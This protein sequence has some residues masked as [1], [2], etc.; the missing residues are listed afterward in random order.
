[1]AS[2]QRVCSFDE[3]E[4]LIELQCPLPPDMYKYKDAN[5]G[6]EKSVYT[7]ARLFHGKFWI[8][9]PETGII[10]EAIVKAK[11]IKKHQMRLDQMR[12]VDD[13]LNA[14]KLTSS[15]QLYKRFKKSFVSCSF[16]L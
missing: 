12:A 10:Y 8:R 5:D 13:Y 9:H 14:F 1:M 11:D 7:T 6:Q 2:A 16:L 4:A 3:W 15:V